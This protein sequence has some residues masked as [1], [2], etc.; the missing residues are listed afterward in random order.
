[1]AAAV[2]TVVVK[3]NVAVEM[4]VVAIIV[5]EMDVV[6]TVT[7]VEETSVANVTKELAITTVVDNVNHKTAVNKI[8]DKVHG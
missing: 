6:E 2:D 1:V 3:I 5:V 7:T 4:D 8:I